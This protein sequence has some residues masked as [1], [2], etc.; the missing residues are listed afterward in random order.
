MTVASLPLTS[1]TLTA[2]NELKPSM[3][4]TASPEIYLLSAINGNPSS[5]HKSFQC[6]QGLE[7]LSG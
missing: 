3:S 4:L 1:V 5:I 7:K 6:K 2:S